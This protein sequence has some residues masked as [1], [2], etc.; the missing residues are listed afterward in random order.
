MRALTPAQRSHVKQVSSLTPLCLPD[1]PPPTTSCIPN[2]AFS[3]TSARSI[4]VPQRVQASLHTLQARR[5]T[6]P[7]RV[8]HP[9][10]YPFASGCF[11]PRL[12]ATRLPSAT[13]DVTSHG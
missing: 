5:Y 9:T 1:I 4:G 2:V 13:C 11:P 12:A 7:K 10:G 8:R 3:V 6:P